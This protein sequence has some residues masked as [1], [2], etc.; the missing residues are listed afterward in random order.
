MVLEGLPTRVMMIMVMAMVEIQRLL[1][2]TCEGRG[3]NGDPTD[4]QT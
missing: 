3:I 2:A 1:P 4:R